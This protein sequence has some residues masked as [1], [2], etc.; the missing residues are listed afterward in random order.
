MGYQ[1]VVP[2]GDNL[3]ALERSLVQIPTRRVVAVI[4]PHA[5]PSVVARVE[6]FLRERGISFETVAASSKSA[7]SFFVALEDLKSKAGEDLLIVNVS[8][9]RPL[10]SYI[11]LCAA[12]ATGVTAIGVFDGEVVFLPVS[13]SITHGR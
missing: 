9:G 4:P 6:S 11:L 2:Y 7:D 13:C 8:V 3:L 5:D 12:M 10:Y 1:Q